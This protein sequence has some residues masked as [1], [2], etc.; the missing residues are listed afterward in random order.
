MNEN[1]GSDLDR[2]RKSLGRQ[3]KARRIKLGKTQS[4]MAQALAISKNYL[5]MIERGQKFPAYRRLLEIASY[6]GTTPSRLMLEAETPQASAEL[7]AFFLLNK[8]RDALA[9]PE[10][11]EALERLMSQRRADEP[12]R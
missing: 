7:E 5:S 12:R 4:D 3:I 9:S 8:L 6:L 1:Q 2:L 10:L 11:R